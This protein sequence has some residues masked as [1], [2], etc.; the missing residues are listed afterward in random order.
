MG[1]AAREM[2]PAALAE[3]GRDRKGVGLAVDPAQSPAPGQRL[4]P[5]QARSCLVSVLSDSVSK[6]VLSARGLI[7]AFYSR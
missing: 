2:H 4:C 3:M 5:R 7:G 6:E 1:H